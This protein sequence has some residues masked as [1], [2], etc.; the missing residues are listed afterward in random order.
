MIPVDL[1][2]YLS[3]YFWATSVAALILVPL[4]LYKIDQKENSR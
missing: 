1:A 2:Y 3:G 4:F